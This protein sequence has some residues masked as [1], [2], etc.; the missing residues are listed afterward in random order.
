MI[1]SKVLT[2]NKDKFLTRLS[3]QRNAPKDRGDVEY[4]NVGYPI[5]RPPTLRGSII[6]V[7]QY[8]FIKKNKSAIIF[9]SPIDTG[10]ILFGLFGNHANTGDLVSECKC[11]GEKFLKLL[12]SLQQE[13]DDKDLEKFY[14]HQL[15]S[16]I[17][18][19][20]KRFF[21]S[22]VIDLIVDNGGNPHALMFEISL[23][24]KYVIQEEDVVELYVP[25]TLNFK[26]VL[27]SFWPGSLTKVRKFNPKYGIE[28]ALLLS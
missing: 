19:I 23:C 22:R 8:E 18:D 21:S 10:G 12:D 11:D 2:L 24:N 28:H 9:G 4:F 5:L 16:N 15:N 1:F 25:N 17:V 20:L 7:L 14:H 3:P 27:P 6:A 13:L 26:E